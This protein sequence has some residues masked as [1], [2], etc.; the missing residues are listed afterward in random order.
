MKIPDMI[1]IGILFFFVMLQAT[2]NAIETGNRLDRMQ[3]DCL[4]SEVR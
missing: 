3:A 2:C 1:T 4:G